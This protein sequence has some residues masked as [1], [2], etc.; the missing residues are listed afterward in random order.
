[1]NLLFPLLQALVLFALA[2]LLSGVTRVAR[3]RLHNRRGPG[4]LQEYRDLIKL[5]GRQSIAPDAAGWVFRLMP[6]VMFGVMLTIATA[7]PVITV[8]SPL[9]VLGDLITLIYLFAIARFFFAIAGLDTGSP[10]TGLGASREAMLGVLVEPILILGLW[11]AALVAGS[12]HISYITAAIYH[13]PAGR[14][15]PL[16][17][18]LCACAF[19][20]FI[21][22]GK[23]PFDLAEAEQELQEGPL[24]EYSGSGFAVLKWGICLK[25]LVV[26]QLFVGVFFPWGQMMHFSVT[27]LLLALA[28]AIVK[29]LVGV[30]V[31]ALFENSMAR[32]RFCATSRVTW[33]G[34][35][36]AFLAFV[37]LLAA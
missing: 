35:G 3:A 17:L 7:L 36:F 16:I 15:L 33:A 18:A 24:T 1:M 32:L 11:V 12:T 22:M 10:F 9:P 34:F 30:L 29:L 28:I 26:L 21:E 27:G 14:S 19:A 20:T 25:Q 6:F 5:F 4:V 23:L 37:S 31:I 8:A 2:P 13:W